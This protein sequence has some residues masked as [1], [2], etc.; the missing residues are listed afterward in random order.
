MAVCVSVSTALA[1]PLVFFV[2][3]NHF[4]SGE[5]ESKAEHL[6]DRISEFAY[7]QPVFWKYSDE[8]LGE[9]L[10]LVKVGQIQSTHRL[11]GLDGEIIREVGQYLDFPSLLHSADVVEG[12]TTVAYVLIAE[13]LQP[14]LADTMWVALLGLVLAA[15]AFVVLRILPL[16]A[17]EAARIRLK[18]Q[19][20]ELETAARELAEAKDVAE[21]ANH[22]KSQFLANMSHELRTLLNAIIGFSEI[23]KDETYGPVGSV[24]Y[25]EYSRDIHGSG[26]HL[27]ALINDILDLSK[28]ESGEEEIL[29]EDIEIGDITQSMGASLVWH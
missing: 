6:A 20:E 9:F 7:A 23:I 29:E 15:S 1:I 5:L 2:T 14:I 27:L 26:H 16:H 12:Q 21:I 25:R 4:V 13:S 11:L 24:K 17:S 19:N 10:Q 3:A 28:V 18:Q 22:A 8:T